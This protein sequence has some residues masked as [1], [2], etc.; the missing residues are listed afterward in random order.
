MAANLDP[1]T[2]STSSDWPVQAADTIERVVGT[3][4]ENTADRLVGVARWV[5]YGI[6]AAFLGI[7]ALV[8][9][10][11]ALIRVLDVYLPSGV[12][13]PDVILGGIFTLAGLFLWSKRSRSEG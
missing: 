5:V 11:V 7:T 8:L 6:L 9:L 4:R 12:W 13:L 2:R 1:A 10:V 3:V